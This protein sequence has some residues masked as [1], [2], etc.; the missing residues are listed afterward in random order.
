LYRLVYFVP[1]VLPSVV[2]ASLWQFLLNPDGGLPSLFRSVGIP[3]YDKALLGSEDT[4][5]WTIAFIDN[6]HYWGFLAVILLVAM[7][8]VPKELYEAARLEGANPAQQL[9]YVTIPEIQ[10]T[11]VFMFMMT[12]IWSF[13]VFDYVWVLT[14]GGPAGSS[15]VLGTFVYKTA[16]AEF[17]AGYAATM[18][19]SMAMFAGVVIMLFVVLRRRGWDI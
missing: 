15:E 13:L 19:V 5:L 3:F 16:F 1:Y 14:Q 18:G 7:Q 8:S 11:L 17:N 6:W 2:V 10:P 12:G 4:A 9:W